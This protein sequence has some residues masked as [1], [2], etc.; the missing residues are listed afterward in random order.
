[1]FED[2]EDDEFLDEEGFA[3]EEGAQEESGNRTF[4]IAAIAL[5]LLTVIAILCIGAYWFTQIRPQ[6]QANANA[7]AVALEQQTSEAQMVQQTVEAS[8]WTA[9]PSQ[10]P[11]PTDTPEATAVVVLPTETERA[12]ATQDPATATVAALLTEAANQPTLNPSEVGTMTAIATGLPDTGMFDDLD[13]TSLILLA[14]FAL[15]VIFLARRMRT[16]NR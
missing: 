12:T 10:T 2:L 8:S 1:M 4:V 3:D 7:T 15:I 6:N 13:V 14:F 9:T 5:G 16:A 11:E